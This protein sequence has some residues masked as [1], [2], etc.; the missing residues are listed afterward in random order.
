[1]SHDQE[2]SLALLRKALKNIKDE[3]IE[4]FL[5]Y[6]PEVT[7]QIMND[8]INEP[9]NSAGP[10]SAQ[11]FESRLGKL[12]TAIDREMRRE[13]RTLAQKVKKCPHCKSYKDYLR[14]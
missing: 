12:S 13:M 6:S 4:V 9:S 7:V 10:V 14:L 5:H 8:L 3:E 11:M 1:M 2:A